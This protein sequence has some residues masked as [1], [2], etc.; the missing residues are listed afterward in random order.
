MP[1]IPRPG[2]LQHLRIHVHG[3]WWTIASLCRCAGSVTPTL[4]T[5][6]AEVQFEISCQQALSSPVPQK[7]S[8]N[9]LLV[10]VWEDKGNSILKIYQSMVLFYARRE[11]K[12]TSSQTDQWQ[13]DSHSHGHSS[14]TR[15]LSRLGHLP[16]LVR[17]LYDTSRLSI[18]WP[19]PLHYEEHSSI[20][21]RSFNPMTE[22][23]LFKCTFRQGWR[24]YYCPNGS[25]R[26]W[27][28]SP[29]DLA[30]TVRDLT[31]QY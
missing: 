25:H 31:I 8:I 3:P 6:F 20:E 9:L 14:P 21:A 29:H 18:K 11:S 30:T 1:G 26:D 15:I 7:W 16:A 28:I 22:L 4:E 23:S 12:D 27:V 17:V 13:Y 2:S 19:S 5:R 10:L 24:R